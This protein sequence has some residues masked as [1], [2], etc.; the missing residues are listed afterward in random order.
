MHKRRGN[1]AF[2]VVTGLAMFAGAGVMALI[3]IASGAPAAVAIALVLAAIPVFPL[4]ACYLWLDRYEPEP[5]GLLALGLGWGAFAATSLALVLQAVDTFAFRSDTT[6]TGVVVAPVTEEAT[7]GLFILL[8]LWLRRA[9]LDG[10]LDGIVYAGMVGIGFAFMENILY[11]TQA[12]VGD[13][14]GTGGIEGAVGLF[15]VRCVFGPFAHP[16]FT[17][18]FGIGVG[19]AVA[20]RR[21]PVRIFAPVVG[22]VVAVLAHALWNGS[23]LIDGGQWAIVTYI[24]MLV[25]AFIM[26][27]LIALWVRSRESRL[28]ATALDDCARR[29]FLH[30]DEI[31]WLVR[32]PGR[33]AARR[34]AREVGGETAYQAMK[35]YQEAAIEL[36]YLHH[37]YLR[38]TAPADYAV[39]GQ[40]HVERLIRL[41]PEIIWPPTGRHAGVRA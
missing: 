15:I 16:F 4:V 6:T 11:L 29:G 37:R 40:E 1:V 21:R 38:G 24:T 33:R 25:P 2:T 22:Y 3:V 34:H 14:M 10:V 27:V 28:L 8:L 36:G 7:K 39:I 17:A 20:S 13:D 23:L 41:R 5:R 18:F 26:F 9:E 31:P 30:P 32:L 19:L 12:Y 35:E